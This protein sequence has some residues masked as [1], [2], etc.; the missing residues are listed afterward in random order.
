MVKKTYV[1]KKN[2]YVLKKYKK[3]DIKAAL[4]EEHSKIQALKI[5]HYIG[6]SQERFDELMICFFDDEWR[7]NQRAAYSMNFVVEKNPKLFK[8][9]LKKAVMNLR[10]AKHDAVKRNTIRILQTYDIPEKLLGTVVDI[11]FE[12]LASPKE[13]VAIKAFSITVLFNIAKKEPDLF[14]E[15]K[16]LI[17]DQMP[18]ASA[19][20]KSR[21]SKVLN[22]IKK[23]NLTL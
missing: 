4:Y 23:N 16:I 14:Y 20:F 22:Y 18:T 5:A 2:P 9:H 8:P 15:L 12:F 3:M 13:A 10:H 19:A 7:L 6:D 21:G 11:C 17:E 1:V